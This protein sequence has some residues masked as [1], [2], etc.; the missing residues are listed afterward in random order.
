[1][2]WIAVREWMVAVA[3]L[4]ITLAT[5]ASLR[6]VLRRM[7]SHRNWPWLMSLVPSVSNLLYIFGLRIFA[8]IAP[9][10]SKLSAWLD[11]G[12]YV[13]A[14]LIVL[15]ML[16]RAAMVAIE[17]SVTKSSNASTLQQG[18]IPLLR[19]LVTLFV[20][21]SGAIMILKRFNYD[22]LSLLTAL[23]VGSLAVGL[24]AKDTLSNMIS[25]F[26]L[27]IDRNL[28]P[29]DRINLSGSIGDVDEIGL[30]STRLRM[31]DGNTLIVPNSDLVNTKILNLS[32]PSREATTSTTFRVP[33]EVSFDQVKTICLE[34][35][36][37]IKRANSARGKWV[38]LNHLNEGCQSITV[39]FWLFD[40]DDA[41]A[42]MTEF[43]ER[44][45]IR[46]REQNIPLFKIAQCA[47]K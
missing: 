36:D 46:F 2:D 13:I 31:G 12:I 9:M 22:V 25:G 34:T 14:V 7:S 39:G 11:S 8:E 3:V 1:M 23:G 6:R 27:I 47:D 29:G 10:S 17:W 37:Q 24:A 35:V 40:M 5:N 33:F 28:R 21:F 19:N 42:A 4:L 16:R 45:L 38:N 32:L 43:N 26:T 30:R 15:G 18:F 20:L 44:L 41:G